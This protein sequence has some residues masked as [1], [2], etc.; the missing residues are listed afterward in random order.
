MI[1]IPVGTMKPAMPYKDIGEQGIE[2]IPSEIGVNIWVCFVL[3]KS[4]GILF[5]V[6][7]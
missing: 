2:L 7:L 6:G 3:C 4:R 5:V 1:A